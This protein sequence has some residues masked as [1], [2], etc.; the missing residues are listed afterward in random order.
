MA[1]KVFIS[2]R[3][4]DSAGHAGRVHDRLAR[5]FGNDLLF[6][7]VDG[8][9][10]G[11][12]YVEVLQE[13]VAK[14]SVLLAVIGHEWLNVRDEDGR[15]RLENPDDFVRVEIAA[16]LQRDIPIIPIMLEGTKVPKANQL[17]KD[18]EGLALRNG[19]GVRHAS[20]HTDI[21]ILIRGLKGRLTDATEQRVTSLTPGTDKQRG[22]NDNGISS[23]TVRGDRDTMPNMQF[24]QETTRQSDEN[25][26][27]IR[28]VIA[29]EL[30]DPR[31]PSDGRLFILVGIAVVVIGA[32]SLMWAATGLRDTTTAMPMPR[33]STTTAKPVID[34]PSIPRNST[35]TM[36]PVADPRWS[37]GFISDVPVRDSTT[38]AKPVPSSRN[39][40][41]TVKPVADPNRSDSH[42]A[43]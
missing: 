42:F 15:R 1:A 27:P 20:F 36:K 38:T 40:T 10:L 2:Y 41:T 18:L 43:D 3:R 22:M 33:D 37:G 23:G 31:R 4:D 16:A 34:T 12:N 32:A 11:V 8:I 35:T 6:M 14:C 19:L 29:A 21:D 25:D 30:S 28:K 9:P 7:D 24:A 26:K 5:E 17:P 13:E 39:S